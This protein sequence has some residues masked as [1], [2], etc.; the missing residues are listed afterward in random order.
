MLSRIKTGDVTDEILDHL[1]SLNRPLK[2]TESGIIP[3]RLYSYR[4][5]VERENQEEFNKLNSKVWGF[6]A[7]DKGFSETLDK[8][9]S[10]ELSKPE[11]EA[12]RKGPL[13]NYFVSWLLTHAWNKP[14]SI[15]YR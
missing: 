8:T 12:Q 3:T 7:V 1:V 15:T 13:P 2:P 11:L 10:W 14:S 9:W 6:A 4:R 5:D